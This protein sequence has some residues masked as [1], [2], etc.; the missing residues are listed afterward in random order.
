ME[1]I[2]IPFLTTD[3]EKKLDHEEYYFDGLWWLIFYSYSGFEDQGSWEDDETGREYW[4]S[5]IVIN[6]FTIEALYSEKGDEYVPVSLMG[7]REYENLYESIKN[8]LQI[9]I[10]L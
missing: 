4:A 10:D 7:K 2:K 8:F 9:N 3:Q 1:V 6:D 5:D